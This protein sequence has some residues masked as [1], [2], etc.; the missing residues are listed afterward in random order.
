MIARGFPFLAVVFTA[1]IL[2][3]QV[4][5][6]GREL[7]GGVASAGWAKYARADRPVACWSIVAFHVIGFAA[8]CTAAVAFWSIRHP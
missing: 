4:A 8:V 1:F 7:I 6:V 3:A 2:A 5:A